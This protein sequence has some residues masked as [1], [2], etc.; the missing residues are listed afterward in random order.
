MTDW[1]HGFGKRQMAQRVCKKT[2]NNGVVYLH[3]TTS[4]PKYL[5]GPS[6]YS[7]AKVLKKIF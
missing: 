4:M 6:A 7:A 5:A 1:Y 2:E 3:L